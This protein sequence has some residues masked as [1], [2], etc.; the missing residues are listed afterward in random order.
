MR[1]PTTDFYRGHVRIHILSNEFLKGIPMYD[2]LK[3][4]IISLNRHTAFSLVPMVDKPAPI[5]QWLCH[6]LMG[7]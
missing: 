6:Q 4:R 7:W 3:P 2:K 5:L 1:V